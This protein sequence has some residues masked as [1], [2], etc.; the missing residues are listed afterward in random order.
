ML[1]DFDHPPADPLPVL[2]AWIDEAWD[3][4]DVP[5]PNAMTLCTVSADGSPHA[6]IVLLKDLDRDGVVF[7]TNQQ[8]LQKSYNSSKKNCVSP[9]RN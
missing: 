3:K 1:M 8:S 2:K 6:R 4:A 7:F 5:N 9:M